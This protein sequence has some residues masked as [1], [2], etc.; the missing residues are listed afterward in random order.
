M[1]HLM[2][3]RL[4]LYAPEQTGHRHTPHHEYEFSFRPPLQDFPILRTKDT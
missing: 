3:R 1:T 4:I 2:P